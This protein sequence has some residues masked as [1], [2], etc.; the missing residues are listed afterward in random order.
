MLYGSME[1]STFSHRFFLPEDYRVFSTTPCEIANATIQCATKYNQC[2]YY[3]FPCA[4]KAFSDIEL[5]GDGWQDG[6]RISKP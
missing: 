2:G 1:L 4:V 6:F 5:R 3:A